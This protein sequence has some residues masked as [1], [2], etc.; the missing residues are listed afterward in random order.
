[1]F[2]TLCSECLFTTFVFCMFKSFIDSLDFH[3]AFMYYILCFLL[4]LLL[5]HQMT[6]IIFP[7][8][9]FHWVILTISVVIHLFN[10]SLYIKSKTEWREILK[11]KWC[12]VMAFMCC[13]ILIMEYKVGK[14]I[15]L[16]HRKLLWCILN[17]V[18]FYIFCYN[19]V[20]KAFYK[21]N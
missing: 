19:I 12:H 2:I 6:D 8:L 11:F 4:Y 7:L 10:S 15:A 13:D 14:I 1:M 9:Y 18:C 21:P 5:Y 20:R 16:F 3:L 17:M